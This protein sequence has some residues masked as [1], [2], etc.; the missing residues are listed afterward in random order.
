MQ[1]Q[2]YY[3]KQSKVITK[4]EY[5]KILAGDHTHGDI[6][7]YHFIAQDRTIW[8]G[9]HI[10]TVW[11][12]M[13]HFKGNGKLNIFETA[14]FDHDYV[15]VRGPFR[16]DTIEDIMDI[17]AAMVTE[18][19]D[20]EKQ[21]YHCGIKIKDKEPKQV[22]LELEQLRALIKRHPNDTYV[23]NQTYNINGCLKDLRSEFTRIISTIDQILNDQKK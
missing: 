11:T 22:P 18:Q 9:Y 14:V 16:H 13:P 20:I 17:H 3:N 15:Q 1:Q 6:R 7:K 23:Y 4:E 2:K 8:G 5:K 12:G 10:S 21:I 19:T